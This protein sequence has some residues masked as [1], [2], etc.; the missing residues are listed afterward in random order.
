MRRA[1]FGFRQILKSI[2][3]I[4]QSAPVIWANKGLE[5]GSA[6]L[7]HEIAFEELGDPKKT[8]RHWGV[9]SGPSFAAE[10]VRSLPT[11]LTL[12]S[13]SKETTMLAAN[14][15]H[16][17]NLRVLYKSGCSRRISWWGIKKCHSNCFW[18]FR[19]NGF[20]K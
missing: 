13:T 4:N 5:Q 16:H 19:W 3:E 11:A 1:Y 2:N 9:V 8:N 14:I 18:N 12:A 15:F 20:W 10:L 17:H 7:P 6:K